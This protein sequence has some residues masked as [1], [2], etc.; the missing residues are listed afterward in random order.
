MCLDNT[1]GSSG[2]GPHGTK[3][4]LLTEEQAAAARL[5]ARRAGTRSSQGC[6]APALGS[7][8]GK[9]QLLQPPLLIFTPSDSFEVSVVTPSAPS[10][11]TELEPLPPPPATAA[12]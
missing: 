1:R 3:P 2:E 8:H 4:R 6:P 7:G 11:A 5:G 9:A 10:P 12:I